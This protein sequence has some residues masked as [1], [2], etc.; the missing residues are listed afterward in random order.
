MIGVLLPDSFEAISYF[1]D[2]TWYPLL[3]AVSD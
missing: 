2:G 1:K 3:P